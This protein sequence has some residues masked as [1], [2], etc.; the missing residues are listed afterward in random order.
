[1]ASGQLRYGVSFAAL[2]ADAFA[3]LDARAGGTPESAQF[4]ERNSY[5]RD[6]VASA[7]RDRHDGLRLSVSGLTGFVTTLHEHLFG[8]R[9]DIETLDRRR[10]LEQA[11][12]DTET[13]LAGPGRHSDSVS[14]LVRELEAD[15]V[16][17]AETLRDRIG[18]SDCTTGTAALVT[19]YERYLELRAELGHPEA[20]SR[21]ETLA[22]V[23]DADRSLAAAAPHLD[24]VVV[25]GLL[26]T[27]AVE[28]ALL[29]R[30]AEA[31]P[32]LVLV[33]TP[34]PATPLAGIGAPLA[35][36]VARLRETGFESGRVD[37]GPELPLADTAAALYRPTTIAETPEAVTWHEAPTP[38]RELCHLARQLRVRLH[39]RDPED[40]LVLAPG[41]LSYRDGLADTFDRYGIEHTYRVTLL[42][43]R[44]YAGRAVLDALACCERLRADRLAALA[45]NP[46]VDIP[47]VDAAE[48]GDCER[49]LYT[50]DI[51]VLADTLEGSP[52]QPFRD[53]TAAVRAADAD[54]VVDAFEG[55]LAWIG[56][57]DAVESLDDRSVDA[58]YERRASERVS[59]VLDS[60]QTVCAATSPAEPLAQL[61][62]AL[63][64]VRVQ[65]PPR[66]TDGRVEVIGLRDTPMTAFEELYVLGATAEH[67]PGREVRPRYVQS[68]GEALGLF[69]RHEGR[70]RDRYRFGTLLAN[71][72]R[73]H[74]TTPAATTDGDPVRPSPFVAELARTTGL[75]RSTGTDSEP[76]GSWT[77]LQRAMAGAGPDDLGP[78]LD[79][80]VA[81]GH[82]S[83]TTAATTLRGAR[84]GTHRNV[85]R[86]TPHDAQ[87]PADA[88]ATLDDDLTREPYSHS[89]LTTYARC[90]FRYMLREGWGMEGTDP[91]EP[92]VSPL[93]VGSVVHET[94]ASFYRRLRSAPGEPVDLTATD[95]T[96]LER[97]LLRAGREAVDR[98]DD[99]FDGVFA[100]ATLDG[101]FAGLATPEANPHHG[102]TGSDE[103]AGTL[104]QFLDTE[105]GRAADGHRPVRFE[106]EF[107]HT[108]ALTRTDGSAL[109]VGGVVDR[110]DTGGDGGLSVLDYKTSRVRGARRRE[111]RALGGLDFQLPLY[112][113]GVSSLFPD[114]PAPE[115]TDVAAGYYVLNTEPRVTVRRDLASRFDDVEFGAFLD[116]TVPTRVERAVGG[117]ERGAFQPA[118]VGADDAPCEH[119]SFRDV[120]DVRH[121]RRHEVIEHIDAED[122]PAY[123]PDGA[124]PGDVRTH[125]PGGD[126]DA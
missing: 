57:D 5:R 16:R 6:S 86:L 98:A 39:E 2:Q 88:L 8:P 101:V 105:L 114:R 113:L 22:A 51:D 19:V 36:T 121:H 24:A 116:S 35:D 107:T 71:A 55:L 41:L 94:V 13:D 10:M 25:S 3:W 50:T 33:P 102:P 40:L 46:L 27:S 80:A 58:G 112:A 89:R 56:L 90:G 96:H 14:E 109:S 20:R 79:E 38:D 93:T 77:D 64:G 44:T 53:R 120:C 42:L 110:V 15:G 81:A 30:L 18:A 111:N 49:R 1:M 32:V 87:L 65:P 124:R 11:L 69:E 74:V 115:P 72:Q 82:L 97:Q 7:W 67:L 78:A 95:R 12:R 17:D 92:G 45:A 43:E 23:A 91:I 106:A 117:I 122:H 75:D 100:E 37:T 85:A 47:G 99:P 59:E 63:S 119:C 31:F 34:T 28:L 62:T 73:V 52:L 29:E 48:L 123:V 83:E 70:D 76:R 9:P 4:V 126:G 21:S 54:E 108:G 125:L 118:V 104:V 84:C 61:D 68:L 66:E 26:D 103:T 60:V